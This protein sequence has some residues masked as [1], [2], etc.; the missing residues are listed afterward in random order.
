[1]KKLFAA[2]CLAFWALTGVVFAQALPTPTQVQQINPADLFQDIVNGQPI[3]QSQY[4][5][6]A[7]IAGVP[8]Y[9]YVV[10]LTAFSIQ[11]LN[12]TSNLYLNPA[13]TLA[14]GTVLLAL[15]PSDG[16]VFCIESTQTQT[17]LTVT[18]A[19]GQT[20]GGSAVTAL[21]ANTKVCWFYNKTIATWL[22]TQ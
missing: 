15:N 16:Q 3:A 10:P 6:A 22:R 11:A 13:G 2:A 4:A 5:S 7:Q 14:T 1:M 17:A 18:G 12:A 21:V 20:V 19:T 8:G 9:Q